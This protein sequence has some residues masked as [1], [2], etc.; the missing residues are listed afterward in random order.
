MDPLLWLA[1]FLSRFDGFTAHTSGGKDSMLTV[2]EAV[3]MLGA[4]GLLDRFTVLHLVLDRERDVDDSRIEWQQV[5]KLAAEQAAR[6]GIPLGGDGGWEVWNTHLAGDRLVSRG[7][8][9][10]RMH[11]ARRDFR[12]TR[13]RTSRG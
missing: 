6:C 10:A 9:A 4:H 5:P 8:W 11:Y 1:W 13:T 2:R 3:R 7:Q 12:I